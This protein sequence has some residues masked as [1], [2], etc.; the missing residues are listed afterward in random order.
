MNGVFLPLLRA[1]AQFDD[2]VF[3][4]VVLRSVVW[5][6]AGFAAV[7]ALALALVHQ[8][9]ALHGPWAWLADLLGSVATALLAFWLFLPVAAAIG[10]LFIERVAL[11]VERRWY[12]ALPPAEAAPILSQ[13]WDG[14]AVG[15]R[16][17]WVN[18][19]TLPLLLFLPGI[20]LV[21]AWAIGA[22]AI[23]RG[24][25]TAVAMRRMSR[26]EALALYG[27]RRALVLTQGAVLAA[28]GY[29]PVLNLLLPVLGTA[30]MV[31]VLD[32]AMAASPPA[33]RVVEPV[34][35]SAR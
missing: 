3:Q 35:P 5:A 23:G 29:L 32:L 12:P 10:T 11:A 25:F 14:V 15:L 33:R 30:A 16:I 13:V 26:A 24:L 17:L 7:F 22:W 1:L 28:M 9:L 21:I 19:I 2:A 27:R 34:A 6:L 31:H 4:G 20:G 18:L 8:V